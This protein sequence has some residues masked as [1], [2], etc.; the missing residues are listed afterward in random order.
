LLAA[1]FGQNKLIEAL[2]FGNAHD[3]DAIE[4]YKA[5]LQVTQ[6]LEKNLKSP[7]HQ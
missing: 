1:K 2:Q 6:H 4:A 7:G 3:R 5:H